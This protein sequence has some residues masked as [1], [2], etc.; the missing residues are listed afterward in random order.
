MQIFVI[1]RQ[2]IPVVTTRPRRVKL[3]GPSG[4]YSLTALNVFFFFPPDKS[5]YLEYEI[6]TYFSLYFINGPYK[7]HF[8]LEQ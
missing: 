3:T 1:L 5:R 8:K 6:R 2:V 4:T 7:K